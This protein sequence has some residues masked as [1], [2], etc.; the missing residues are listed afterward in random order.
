MAVVG[1]AH[2][3]I[4]ALTNTL[5]T[6]ISGALR[7]AMQGAGR[8]SGQDFSNEFGKSASSRFNQILGDLGTKMRAAF[9][10][11]GRDAAT[12]FGDSFDR[13]MSRRKATVKVDIDQAAF[14]A[15]M[16]KVHAEIDKV[17]GKTISITAEI[18]MRRF[19]ASLTSLQNQISVVNGQS[20]NV[21]ADIDDTGFLASLASMQTAMNAVDGRTLKIDI[22]VDVTGAIAELTTLEALI[23]KLDGQTIN[24]D[25]DVHDGGALGKL[26]ALSGASNGLSNSFGGLSAQSK[27]LAVAI[28]GLGGPALGALASAMSALPA[29]LG[30]VAVGAGVVALGFDGI[31]AAAKEMTP[32]ITALREDISASF[33]SGL[34]PMFA[35]LNDVMNQLAPR[36]RD[37]SN[38]LIGVIQGIGG[39]LTSAQGIRQLNTL[40][41][42]TEVFFEALIPAVTGFTS[43]LLTM[44]ADGSQYL[45]GLADAI[46]AAT[47]RFG[48]MWA[49]LR[50]SGTLEA[51][52]TG[53]NSIIGALLDLIT[54]LFDAGLQLGAALN[55]QLAGA[56]RGFGQLL[57]GLVPIFSVLGSLF[58]GL[59]EG[60]GAA[61]GPLNQVTPAFN[62]LGA[63]IYNALVT[64]GGAAGQVIGALAPALVPVAGVVASLATA[65]GT[66]LAQALQIVL[67]LAAPIVRVFE[68]LAPPIQQLISALLP[69]LQSLLAAIAPLI[70]LVATQFGHVL[71]ALQPL[72]QAGM[73]LL[74]AVMQPLQNIIPALSPV[75]SALSTAFMAVVN[76]VV[77]LIPPLVQVVNGLMP[78]LLQVV[79]A[80][81]PVIASLASS[82]LD[83]VVA[84]LPLVPLLG[85]I[86]EA[87]LPVFL[88]LVRAILPIIPALASAF[89]E[90]IAA[91]V[92]LIPPLVDIV[93]ALLPPLLDL[94]EGIMPIVPVLAD[95]FVGLVEALLPIVPL[96]AD[97]VEALLPVFLELIEAITPIFPVLADAV[98]QVVTAIAPLLP[99]IGEL[100]A[101][102]LPPFVALLET[103]ADIIANVVVP[104]IELFVDFLS[105]LIGL[106]A[107]V[108]ST[109]ADA[110]TWLVQAGT[111]LVEGLRT[112]VAN[113]WDAFW[114]WLTDLWQSI[115]DWFKDLFGIES[116]STVFADFGMMIIQGLLNGLQSLASSVLDFFTTLWDNVQS[117]FNTAWTALQNAATGVWNAIVSLFTTIWTAVQGIWENIWNVVSSVFQTIWSTIQS[118]A[119]SVWNSL[120]N[121]Y[122]NAWTTL[123]NLWNTVWTAIQNFFQTTWNTIQS[124]GT[125]IWNAISSFF[126]NAFNAYRNLFET[127]WTAV[128]NFF[129]RTWE[130]IRNTAESIWNAISNFFTNAFNAYRNLFEN[131]W[132][133]IRNFFETT[134]NNIQRTAETIWNAISNFFTSA[135]NT[136]RNLFE[137]V[138]T[139]IRN[140][141]ETT[142]NAIQRIAET[143]W[144]AI[145]SFFSGAF[146]S[147]RTFFQNTWDTIRNFFET[148][149]NNIRST[150]ERI[151]NGIV[152]FFQNAW[153]TFSGLWDSF[154][155]GIVSNATNIF[156]GLVN[157]LRGIWN[158]IIGVVEGGVNFVVR[159]INWPIEKINGLFGLT[160][161]TM[162]PVALPRLASGGHAG[163]GRVSGIGGQRADRAPALLSPEEHVWSAREVRGAGG[164]DGV[165]RLREAA[166]T[167]KLGGDVGA[168]YPDFVPSAVRPRNIPQFSLGGYMANGRLVVPKMATAD[169]IAAVVKAQFPSARLTSGYRPGDPGYHGKNQAAD[170]AG[171]TPAPNGSS[172]MAD[173]EQWWAGRYGAT[174]TELIYDGSGNKQA[175]LYQGKP[176]TYSAATQADHHNHVH[177]AYT[178]ALGAATGGVLAAVADA[179]A[180]TG[181]FL[182]NTMAEPLK[183]AGEAFMRSVVP[184]VP[185]F[186]EPM[187]VGLYNKGWDGLKKM[188]I[189]MLDAGQ[190]TGAAAGTGTAETGGVKGI[191]SQ[192]FASRGWGTGPQWTATDWIVQKE[193]AWNPAAQN[194]VSTASGLFQH[195]NATWNA[196]KR[197]GVTASRMR[198]ASVLEQG[199]A[200]MNYIAARYGTPTA[201]QAFWVANGHY[202]RGGVLKPGYTLAYNGLGHD[203]TILPIKPEEFA[204]GFASGGALNQRGTGPTSG[205]SWYGLNRNDPYWMIRNQL[206]WD[207]NKQFG[208]FTGGSWTLPNYNRAPGG[209]AAPPPLPPR[210]PVPPPPP[211]PPPPKKADLPTGDIGR[212]FQDTI[213]RIAPELWMT[214]QSGALS[215]VGQIANSILTNPA[216]LSA[217]QESIS[218]QIGGSAVNI[219]ELMGNLVSSVAG[220]RNTAPQAPTQ[221]ATQLL[222]TAQDMVTTSS[223]A[224]TVVAK[225]AVQ[226]TVQVN[227]NLDNVSTAT[228]QATLQNFGTQIVTELVGRT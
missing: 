199:H 92:R 51:A 49:R 39:V 85:D 219:Q 169:Q 200:G 56:L 32:S 184:N 224:S 52:L 10:T 75:I 212:I 173:L 215:Q 223:S 25:V 189:G 148:T 202:D 36:L 165:R 31:K 125:S 27:I 105:S 57:Q 81:M 195:I 101:A 4:H 167:G 66:L 30:G 192:V 137:N 163:E 54:D 146:N 48:D 183:G 226:A 218:S 91:L 108:I 161:G 28:L 128:S 1:S 13:E 87:L 80:L 35:D 182:W 43:N 152:S 109:V 225:G 118:I 116:P 104:A 97:L 168:R 147:F 132:T 38:A 88:D 22:D 174:T 133:A 196:Y 53:L 205:I 207:R 72:I 122:Q 58:L 154:W 216:R 124:I 228:L 111:D 29:I 65:F 26:G 9:T 113:A 62:N 129:S 120:A 121:F 45:G 186:L 191:V 155:K 187:G 74:A 177:I 211:P 46:A 157:G 170:M 55:E 94:I 214:L 142:W 130:T 78:V 102:L 203:E 18:D 12:S 61:L 59:I 164:H 73:Q 117:I 60:L 188:V 89:A 7:R 136:F 98:V 180:V 95:A 119:T 71:T 227:G 84:L 67:P 8:D 140:F 42:Q 63:A 110:V 208:W 131:V 23:T 181:E 90:V 107:D 21:K 37:V 115:I 68:M 20:I 33:E 190:G 83:V 96:L 47:D 114:G 149:W 6:E 158:T 171:P 172:F 5:Q 19:G 209:V 176:H 76:V 103:L 123:Q 112:G 70:Q 178:G 77:S 44:A 3:E 197:P 160:I 17:T 135:F 204:Q 220:A 69:I 221:T 201:A 156:N 159:G 153:S 162:A 139:A 64:V 185:S 145:S 175:D 93:Q 210:P 86:V 82:F 99:A 24:I 34:R 2:I 126:T 213:Q 150:A 206:D 100:I 144:N 14:T 16:A 198:D 127:V 106:A 217:L 41:G 222:N 179:V 166:R 15:S 40:V 11:H 151:W 194:P 193:S 141:F 138:W 50:E 79:A 134:W 143:I